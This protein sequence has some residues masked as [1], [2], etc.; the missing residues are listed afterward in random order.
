MRREFAQSAVTGE[1][2]LEFA[3]QCLAAPPLARIPLQL[4]ARCD[5]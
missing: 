4:V 1:E 3:G 2:H 5:S